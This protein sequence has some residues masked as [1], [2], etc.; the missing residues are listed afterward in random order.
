MSINLDFCHL[1]EL[2]SQVNSWFPDHID[3]SKTFD[4][5]ELISQVSSWFPDHI[6]KSRFFSP[7]RTD[8]PGQFWTA[9]IDLSQQELA[10]LR[11]T[12]SVF[13]CQRV[14]DPPCASFSDTK[15]VV[16]YWRS[17]WR[18]D[19]RTFLSLS[20]GNAGW[21][22]LNIIFH[23]L[24]ACNRNSSLGCTAP[25]LTIET[26]PDSSKFTKPEKDLCSGRIILT[27]G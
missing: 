23:C 10:P 4:L 21:T 20:S 13:V 27:K 6:N 1:L 3:K 16:Q 9:S 25:V 26:P 5:S 11:P 14:G 15:M 18:S 7:V 24:Y 2:I 12:P 22:N 17:R 19:I 8:F